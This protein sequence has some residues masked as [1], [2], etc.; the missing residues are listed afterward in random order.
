VKSVASQVPAG[1]PL[2]FTTELMDA[3]T[4]PTWIGP[5]FG[6]SKSPEIVCALSPGYIAA[7]TVVWFTVSAAVVSASAVPVPAPPAVQYAMAA[8]AT[9]STATKAIS[10]VRFF[11]KLGMAVVSTDRPRT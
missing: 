1:A 11:L 3:V 7:S 8:P 9:A 10:E 4:V 5:G 2:A 6:L